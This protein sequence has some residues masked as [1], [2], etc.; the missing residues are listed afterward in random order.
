[1]ETLKGVVV[2]IIERIYREERINIERAAELC[3]KAIEG[4]GLIY[5]FGTG[6][7]MLM[8][9]ELFY[10]AG[11]LAPIYPILDPNLLGLSGGRL[12]TELERLPGYAKALFNYYR[13]KA[14]S[15]L[16]VISVSGKNAAPVEAALE[17]KARGLSVVAVTSVE[18]S[19]RLRPANP[20]GKRL[21]EVADVVIDNKVPEGDAAIEVYGRKTSAVSN[22]ANAFI[23]HAIE[24]EVVARLARRGVEPELWTSVNVPGGEERNREL[25]E[26]YSWIKFL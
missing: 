16:I 10:R 23:L 11:G 12:S 19:K 24:A 26:K 17:G 22:I 2:D 8:A 20:Y 25:L 6:H 3:A 7:S 21:Y 13:P 5:L 18:Y 14:G 1:V 15:A 4:G 9:L